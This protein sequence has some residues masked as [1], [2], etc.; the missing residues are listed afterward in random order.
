MMYTLLK[1]AAWQSINFAFKFP[2]SWN[3]CYHLQTPKGNS[4]R[5]GE[6]LK[7]KASL[8]RTARVLWVQSESWREPGDWSISLENCQG[9]VSPSPRAKEEDVCVMW[10]GR[11][12]RESHAVCSED[13]VCQ[14][15]SSRGEA[16]E[17]AWASR[18]GCCYGVSALLEVQ[19]CDGVCPGPD[20]SPSRKTLPGDLGVPPQGSALE[21]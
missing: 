8:W 10:T 14:W 21:E 16:A 2:G 1:I 19:G 6:N 17:A 3:S 9:T 4:R 11:R 12:G 15:N 5:A 7:I 13:C 18:R 20:R